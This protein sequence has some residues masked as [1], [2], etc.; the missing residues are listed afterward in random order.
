MSWASQFN[1]P[2]DVRKAFADM[3]SV[4]ARLAFEQMLSC[5]ECGTLFTD[6]VP[7]EAAL[8]QFYSSHYGETVHTVHL[9]KLAR[10][11]A[12][13][14]RR[15]FLLRW[16]TRGRRFLDVGC[17]LG[18]AVEAARWNGFSATG[19]ELNPEAVR[20][21][22]QNFPRNQFQ[23]S[24]IDELTVTQSFDMVYCTEVIEHVPDVHGFVG[25]LARALAPGGILFLTTPDSG[26]FSVRRDL[27]AWDNVKPPEHLTLFTR[28]GL[29]EALH[30]LFHPP[31]FFPNMKPG[32]QL[33]ARRQESQ[34]R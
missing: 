20:L 15:I 4:D 27:I 33:I 21:A 29:T 12:L 16:L 17:N 7:P 32:I 13:E 19:I 3:M 2:S 11:L 34:P 18:C 8:S 22:R 1:N 5:D 6:R 28:K 30:G 31:W 24:T 26:H 10:K 23:N 25:S 9:G 14:K